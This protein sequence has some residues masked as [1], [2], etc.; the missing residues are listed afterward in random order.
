MPNYPRLLAAAAVTTALALVSGGCSGNSKVEGTVSYKGQ[1]VDGATVSLV[2]DD[3]NIVASGMTDAS[4]KFTLQ[5]PQG[6]DVIPAGTYKA[7][8][9]KMDTPKGFNPDQMKIE[10]GGKIDPN[11]AKMMKGM[12]FS[13]PKSVLPEKFRAKESTPLKVTVPAK[14]PIN[15][16]LD[17]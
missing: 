6:K 9:T 2:A 13:P 1:P 15:L 10:E 8:V 5:T 11:M 12:T 17:S 14:E 3:G 16:N 4:G 7:T